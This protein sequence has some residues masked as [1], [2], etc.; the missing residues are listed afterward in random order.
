MGAAAV[1]HLSRR[2]RQVRHGCAFKGVGGRTVMRV[3]MAIK[4]AKRALG[5]NLMRSILT[6]LGVIIGVGRSSP[7]SPSGRGR[8]RRSGPKSPALEPTRWSSY[9]VQR[10]KAGYALAG[11]SRHPA[12]LGCEGYPARVSCHG[13]CH[14]ISA[15]RD[16]RWSMR[17]RTGLPASRGPASNTRTS[18]SG[19]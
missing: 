2:P 8:M 16:G 18:G 7:W 19:H 1:D 6:M 3:F 17:I 5:R 11:V 10:R 4:I 13:L 9:R 12:A 15:H 14:A